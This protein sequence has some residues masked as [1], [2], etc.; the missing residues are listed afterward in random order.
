MSQLHVENPEFHHVRPRFRITVPYA[1][2]ELTQRI[3]QGLNQPNPPCRGEAGHG[4]VSLVLPTEELHYWSPQL[5]L[6]AQ[7]TD[8]GTILRGMYTPKPSVWMMFVFFYAALGFGTLVISIV[9]F[10]NWSLGK[11]ATLLWLVPVLLA[12]FLS[13]YLV[14]YFGKKTGYEQMVTLHHFIEECIGQKIIP[15]D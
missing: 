6:S 13:L 10:S 4:Y 14:A 5:S 15:E 8:E 9:G 3:K 12:A 11:D 7:E 1:K 2:E